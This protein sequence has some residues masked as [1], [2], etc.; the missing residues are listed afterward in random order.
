M[1]ISHRYKFIFIHIYK[2]GGSSI[3][4]SLNKYCEEI[5]RSQ[6]HASAK[7]VKNYLSDETGTHNIWDEY[8]T[9]AMVRNP[10]DFC[11]SL[12]H[13]LVQNE[14][15]DMNGYVGGL[16]GFSEFLEHL[17]TP[18]LSQQQFEHGSFQSYRRPLKSFVTDKAGNLIVDFVGRFEDF[19]EDFQFICRKI[20]VQEQLLHTN[21]SQHPD[22]RDCYDPSSRSLVERLFQDDI[23]YFDYSF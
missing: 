11:V 9:F 6:F 3:D 17:E 13:W 22:Y 5:D 8:F 19:S 14:E 1:L 15:H 10:W 2:T 12:Y 7:T 23:D 20:G 16:S 4:E 21:Q 18:G